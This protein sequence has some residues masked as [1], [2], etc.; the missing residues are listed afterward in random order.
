MKQWFPHRHRPAYVMRL[1]SAT[2][3]AVVTCLSAVASP[4]SSIT[5]PRGAYIH[6]PF[7]RRRCFYCNFPIVVVGDRP[8]SQEQQG[9]A[10]TE[11]LL[12]EID[13]TLPAVYNVHANTPPPLASVYFGGGTPSLLPIPCLRAVLARLGPFLLGGDTEVTLEMDPGT[14]TAATLLELEGAG[15]TRLSLGIQS[16]DDEILRACGRAH[17]ADDAWRAIDTIHA[18]PTRFKDNFSIDL[19]ASLPHLTLP[20]WETTLRQ[21]VRTGC[22]HVSVYDLQVEDKTA[23]G[24]WYA[25]G[26]FPLPSDADAAAMYR[27]AA[28][29]LTSPSD[30]GE[31]GGGFEH[32]EV[33]NY[34]KPGKRSRHNQ[35]Y[36][37]CEQTLG[38]GM[39]AASFL[40]HRRFTR[41]GKLSAYTAWL[42]RLAVDGLSAATVPEKDEDADEDENED[43]GDAPSAPDILEVVM[44]ALRT[45][46]GLCLGRLRD[47]YGAGAEEQVLAA[48]APF[49]DRGLVSVV[50]AT[51][52]LVDPDGF[53]VSNDIISSVFVELTHDVRV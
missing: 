35:L 44:L 12:R 10:Y 49:V 40:G 16:F 42:E 37:R 53:L 20:R 7:C 17:T 25:P 9:E 38:F 50:N 36:W 43:E 24:R 22:S 30:Q 32:Y 5:A 2:M 6:V 33:S 34:A 15:V 8:S 28:E 26:V 51:V 52:R 27:M 39:G 18:S 45:A 31:G 48:V 46:D 11:L 23:F 47:D 1:M 13:L 19:I 21:A 29:V 14:F 3:V 41:P 4:S